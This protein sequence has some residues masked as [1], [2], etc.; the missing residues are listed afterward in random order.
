VNAGGGKRQTRLESL[1]Q[2]AREMWQTNREASV[3]L[4]PALFSALVAPALERCVATSSDATVHIDVALL[5]T[6]ATYIDVLVGQL[7][8]LIDDNSGVE[9]RAHLSSSVAAFGGVLQ[10]LAL[11][12]S[13]A[14]N[15][16]VDALL[17][18]AAA[19]ATQ[20]SV[21]LHVAAQLFAPLLALNLRFVLTRRRALLARYCID[22]DSDEPSSASPASLQR[23]NVAAS[24]QLETLSCYE[25]RATGTLLTIID[26]NNNNDGNNNDNDGDSLDRDPG[27]LLRALFAASSHARQLPLAFAD[28]FDVLASHEKRFLSKKRDNDVRFADS[29]FDEAFLQT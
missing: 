20:P 17:D 27:A 23:V 24:L 21:P 26:N 4:L 6:R 13:Y 15:G 7:W 22:V 28:L 3:V 11:C 5:R 2:L 19:R 18:A 29:W 12:A 16:S 25:W 10:R 1:L 8:T 14:P 9:Q